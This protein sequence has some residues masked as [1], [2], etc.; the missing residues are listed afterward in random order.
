MRAVGQPDASPGPGPAARAR[1][2]LPAEPPS[3]PRLHRG[4]RQ[5]RPS[6]QPPPLPHHLQ[7]SGVGWLIAATVLTT[8]STVIFAHGLRGPAVGVTVA[9]DAVTRWLATAR[10][11]RLTPI[12]RGLADAGSTPVSVVAGYALVAALVMLRRF[13]HLLVLVASVEAANLVSGGMQLVVHR[14]RPFGVPVRSGWGGF[15]LP[16]VQMVYLCAVAVGVL[17]ALVPA[18][19]WR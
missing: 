13:R 7:G 10:V 8:A 11:P 3:Q 1:A 6:G 9:D 15:A 14:P 19:R 18:G 4:S 16:S 12:A 17:Y 5:R 2:A